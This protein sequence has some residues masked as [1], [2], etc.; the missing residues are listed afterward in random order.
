VREE[1]RARDAKA[2][3]TREDDRELGAVSRYDR[4]Q[5]LKCL[6]E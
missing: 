5:L 1:L 6:D 4:V 3:E 2:L